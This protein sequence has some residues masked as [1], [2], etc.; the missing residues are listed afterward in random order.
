M[1]LAINIS[2]IFLS[3]SAIICYAGADDKQRNRV[4]VRIDVTTK[5]VASDFSSFKMS[6]Y[7]SGVNIPIVDYAE[8]KELP[9]HPE[10]L[11]I[12]VREPEEIKDTGLIPTA[13]AIPLGK[14][15]QELASNVSSEEFEKKY[16]RAK[17]D[18]NS[19]IILHCRSGK[20]SQAAAEI[21]TSLGYT[22][23]FNY[24][25]SWLDWAEREGL[26]K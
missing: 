13:I 6:N 1:R 9:K 16:G 26:P 18:S 23:V 7:S 25:G 10:K 14:V 22:N 20:R 8:V 2:I 19:Y 24:A 4:K 17:P 5:P 11:L 21:V 3:L 12:D 15:G